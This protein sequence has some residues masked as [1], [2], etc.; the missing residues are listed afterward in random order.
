MS[1]LFLLTLC[2]D[3]HHEVTIA[4]RINLRL[5]KEVLEG[6]EGLFYGIPVIYR[7]V[8]GH[9]S[10]PSQRLAKGHSPE[11]YTCV[12]VPFE[13]NLHFRFPALSECGCQIFDVHA[14]SF[15]VAGELEYRNTI[16]N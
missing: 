1:L 14:Q 13:E 10:P 11:Q 7:E 5:L 6:Y 15:H 4:P 8:S 2:G 3:H 12:R 9:K 16:A